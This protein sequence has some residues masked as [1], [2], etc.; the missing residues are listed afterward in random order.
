MCI[1]VYMPGSKVWLVH[2]YK[3]GPLDLLEIVED[4]QTAASVAQARNDA[5]CGYGTI[6]FF[7]KWSEYGWTPKPPKKPVAKDLFDGSTPTVWAFVTDDDGHREVDNVFAT[8]ELARRA[9]ESAGY[10]HLDDEDS[11]TDSDGGT[12]Y[13]IE[14]VPVRARCPSV[15]PGVVP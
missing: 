10:R 12:R 15:G 9:A 3:H 4:E 5:E 13:S 6:D 11:E 8:R 1:I 14:A 7:S 2:T